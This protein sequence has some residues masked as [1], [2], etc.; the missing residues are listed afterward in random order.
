MSFSGQRI[1][2][3][4]EQASGAE[5]PAEALRLVRELRLEIDD[6][7]RQQVARALSAGESVSAV[8]RALGV[9]RQSA[10]RRFR[11]LVPAK[12]HGRKLRPMPE[13]RIAVEYAQREAKAVGASA[14]GSEHLLLGILRSGDHPVVSRLGEL[15]I[16]FEAAQDACRGRDTAV[17]AD[18]PKAVLAAAARAARSAGSRRVGLEHLLAGTLSDPAGGANAVVRALGVVPEAV[19]ALATSSGPPCPPWPPPRG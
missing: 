7:E 18:E 9:Q 14:V 13:V 2:R 5:L 12:A 17:P 16:E 11:D 6:F 15:G 19:T 3:L 4:A 8:A 10:H 1:C